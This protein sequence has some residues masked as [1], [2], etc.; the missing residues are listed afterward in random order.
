MHS[1]K[2]VP[3]LNKHKVICEQWLYINLCTQMKTITSGYS[4]VGVHKCAFMSGCAQVCV[5]ECEWTT[6]CAR[7]CIASVRAWACVYACN[8]ICVR[9]Y[10]TDCV[11]IPAH[12]CGCVRMRIKLY[13]LWVCICAY[14]CICAVVHMMS[15]CEHTSMSDKPW[16]ASVHTYVYVHASVNVYVRMGLSFVW[17]FVPVK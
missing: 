4:R 14:V 2:W 8:C 9:K 6:V 17:S 1:L 7:V 3:R 11:Y 16:C 15:V 10:A 13:Y 5:H 12:V